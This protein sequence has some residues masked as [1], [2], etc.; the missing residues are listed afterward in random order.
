[1]PVLRKVLLDPLLFLIYI[2]DLSDNF[3]CNPKLFTD[4]TSLFSTV[5]V[6]GRTANNVNN[7]LKE[8]NGLS[9]GK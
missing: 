9:R 6:P 7:D 8:I 4:N 5:K 3:Q 2:S 1:M